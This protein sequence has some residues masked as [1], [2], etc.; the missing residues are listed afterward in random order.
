[1]NQPSPWWSAHDLARS[2]AACQ[3]AVARTTLTT[4]TLLVRW[5]QL[6]T[7]LGT[8]PVRSGCAGGGTPLRPTRR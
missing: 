3:A 8:A 5:T 2:A 6:A 7:S 1:M 4:A